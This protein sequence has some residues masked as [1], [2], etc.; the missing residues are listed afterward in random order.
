MSLHSEYLNE[1]L[2]DS[3][4]EWDNGFATYRF[5]DHEGVPSVYIVDI[6]VRPD[7]RKTRMATEMADEIKK[8]AMRNGCKRMIGSV[9]AFIKDPTRSIKVLL[10][11]GMVFHKSTDAGIVFKKEIV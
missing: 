9:N 8:V 4:I 3:I 6:Y 1:L 5:I 11:Y 7:F 10:G 2:G